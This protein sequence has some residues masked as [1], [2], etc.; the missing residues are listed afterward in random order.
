MTAKSER[1]TVLLLP[2]LLCDASIWATQADAMRPY[3]LVLIADFSEHYSLEAM[4]RSALAMTEAPIIAINHSMG[5]RVAME[6]TALASRFQ[7]H[8]VDPMTRGTAT[9]SRVVQEPGSRHL[10]GGSK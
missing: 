5:A 9:G 6:I 4:A 1:P 7:A 10:S 2:E 3:A 8:R